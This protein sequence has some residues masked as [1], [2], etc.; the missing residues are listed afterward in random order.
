MIASILETL[1]FIRENDLKTIFRCIKER[2]VPPFFQFCLYG[3][4][5]V[6]AL[7]LNLGIIYGLSYTLIPAAESSLING[8]PITN[9]QRGANL[10]INTSISFFIVNAFVYTMNILLVF[11][12]GR[13]GAVKEFLFFTAVNSPSLIIPLFGPWLVHKYGISNAMAI[14]PAIVVSALINFIARRFFIFKG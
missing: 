4:C 6:M 11:K 10:A 7:V 14:Y 3:F 9:E 13:H 12:R 2:N 8:V 5:G 1:R